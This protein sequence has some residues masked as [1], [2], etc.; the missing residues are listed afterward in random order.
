MYQEM[1]EKGRKHKK[2]ISRGDGRTEAV[3]EGIYV[4]SKVGR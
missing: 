1:R 4:V 2:N 3:K